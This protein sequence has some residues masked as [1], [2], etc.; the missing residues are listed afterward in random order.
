MRAPS[1]LL[2]AAL[3]LAC[4][5]GCVTSRY[6]CPDPGDRAEWRRL[7]GAHVELRTDLAPARAEALL[8]G[9][10]QAWWAHE[11]LSPPRA[12]GD[13]RVALVVLEDPDLLAVMSGWTPE[14]RQLPQTTPETLLHPRP[15]AMVLDDGAIAVGHP[16]KPGALEGGLHP[17]VG[18]MARWR[19]ER[20]LPAGPRWVQTGLRLYLGSVA[21]RSDGTAIIGRP[22]TYAAVDHSTL[23][24]LM[25]LEELWAASD[26]PLP[27]EGQARRRFE[28]TSWRWVHHL[29]QR[30]Q[31]RFLAFLRALHETE[32]R[33]AWAR[34]FGAL[35]GVRLP[36]DDR[37][38]GAQTL[39]YRPPAAPLNILHERME[40]AEVHTLHA[41][42]R[43]LHHARA[44]GD[45]AR[46][47]AAWEAEVQ[48]ALERDP[49]EVGAHL[50]DPVL[51]RAGAAQRV[52]RAR[53]LVRARPEDPRAWTLLAE[54]L[55]ASGAPAE[56]TG[57]AWQDAA[58]RFPDEAALQGGLAHWLARSGRA[59]EA[60]APARRAVALQPLEPSFLATLAFALASVGRC[61]EAAP[62][63][64]RAL[65]VLPE[66][67]NDPRHAALQ[68]LGVSCQPR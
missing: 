23:A 10:E 66:G 32:P 31:P 62:L 64:A 2:V 19:L 30:E 14:R 21:V 67:A 61:D 13:A 37:E 55:E 39:T 16:V 25:S 18:A 49:D 36:P 3:A 50:S 8:R 33:T 20:A 29:A 68:R 28:A 57:E 11:A 48:L 4:I 45:D 38:T 54:A 15:D 59:E 34:T 5:T 7:R 27:E 63:Q 56:R 51:L 42:L 43:R 1:L 41:L 44:A 60:L 40:P 17:A 52:E 26:A 53:H 35:E 9:L 6:A 65:R 47:R 58:R 24:P 12:P 46:V 22:P